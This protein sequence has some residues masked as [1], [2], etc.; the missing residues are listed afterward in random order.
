MHYGVCWM[1]CKSP[2]P[3]RRVRKRFDAAVSAVGQPM[4]PA[5]SWPTVTFMLISIG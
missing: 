1:T 2:L 3:P 4:S 5:N